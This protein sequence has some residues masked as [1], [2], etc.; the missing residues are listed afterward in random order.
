MSI[1][2][3][4][5]KIGCGNTVHFCLYIFEGESICLRQQN[6]RIIIFMEK[7]RA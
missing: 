7:V 3:M 6:R 2:L 5:Y 4:G 1:I